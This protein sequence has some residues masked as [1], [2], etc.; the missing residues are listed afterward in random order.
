MVSREEIAKEVKD[1][2]A[3]EKIAKPTLGGDVR[4][5]EEMVKGLKFGREQ[6]KDSN[7]TLLWCEDRLGRKFPADT[8][9]TKIITCS[10]PPHIDRW[11]WPGLTRQDQLDLIWESRHL[12]KHYP[13]CPPDVEQFFV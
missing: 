5:T 7:G 10:R 9:G 11:Y 13:E 2:E 6:G 1:R 12:A 8:T 3:I 4:V